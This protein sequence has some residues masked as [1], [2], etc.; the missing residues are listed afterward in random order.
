[1]VLLQ[2]FRI[3][4]DSTRNSTRKRQSRARQYR[5]L[6]LNFRQLI[7]TI[8]I[9]GAFAL[10]GSAA[11]LMAQVTGEFVLASHSEL[12]VKPRYYRWHVDPGVEWVETNTG[13]AQLEWSIPLSQAAI[14]LVDVWDRHYLKDTQARSEIVINEHLVPLL[15][16]CR[17]AGMTIIHAP[18]APQALQHPSW[19]GAGVRS[20]PTTEHDDWP[21]P[22]FRGK[23]GVFE[24]FRRPDEPREPELAQ[25]RA[26]LKI[27]PK[28]L[29]IKG[30]PAVATGEE[31]HQFCKQSGI[32]FLFF[33][34]FNTN[35]CVLTR[36]YGTLAMSRRGYEVIL[37]R[38]CTTGM[39][40]RQS[41]PAMSQT[42]SAILFLEMFGQ[43]SV[44]S[45]ELCAGLKGW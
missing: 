8:A 1:M 37:I 42:A 22:E 3:V 38:D 45:D 17:R 21:P 2:H 44:T 33:A 19:V 43:Y 12:H 40:S 24:Q 11:Q 30:E 34:G 7:A 25:L 6:K 18:S 39:E 13:Y 23:S 20:M 10:S 35:A 5:L 31:L 26:K 36:D 14:V 4:S 41:Q 27:H 29:P 9:A 15:S 16:Q 28:V 32:L